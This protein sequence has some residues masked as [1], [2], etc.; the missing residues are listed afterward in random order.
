MNL[1]IKHFKQLPLFEAEAEPLV[2][3]QPTDNGRSSFSDPAF[4][5]NKT[6]PVH[7]WVPWIAGFSREFVR[8]ALKQYLN[9]QGIVLDPF[10]GVG[11]TLVEAILLG[12]QVVG[13]EINPYAA[14]ACQVK[15]NAYQSSIESL[16][17]EIERFQSFYIEKV[18][19]DY[20][21][22]SAP[23]KEF[24]TR[25]R[26][27]SPQVLRKVLIL[28][29]FVDSIKDNQLQNL[30]RIAFS[31]TMVRYSN[32][33]YEPSLG[34]RVSAGK[35]EIHDFSVGRAIVEKLL[36]IAQ[37]ISWLQ[38]HLPAKEV[39]AKIINDSFFRYQNYL[40]SESIDLI[41]TS[42]PYLNN[43]HYNRNTRPQLYWLGYAQG[44]Q[45]LKPLENDNFGKYW[46][47][48]REQES[49]S[50]TFSLPHS[51]IEE[52]LEALR[53]INAQR[54]IYGGNGWANYAASYF[55]DCYGFAIGVKHILK[56]G[57]TALVVIGNSILQGIMMPTDKYLGQIA[58]HIGL[59]LVKIDIPR[60]TRI[61]NSII[62]SNV[63][64]AK[65]KDSHRLYEAV[66]ELRKR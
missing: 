30:F 45:D 40:V 25:A 22:N 32:Y 39:N 9:H 52:R 49:L 61:G 21:P 16:H 24:K 20:V 53:E 1:P 56:P 34:R 59:E 64:V 50:L 33:S 42:P 62:Q 36:E 37:D 7:R 29:D 44:P 31:S 6:L 60:A 15:V 46:Q 38:D 4:A 26:F 55:N 66:L 23:P 2:A 10:A 17:D 5:T 3:S 35:E 57:G 48:V 51:D 8:G 13:F 27:Y 18:S 28:H 43:Y 54:G 11:T 12:H 41:I 63:R 47:T 14:F 19:S 58:E 65:A